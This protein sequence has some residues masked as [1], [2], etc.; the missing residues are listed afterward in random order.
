DDVVTAS[1]E[2]AG[3]RM[4]NRL[5]DNGEPNSM[6]TNKSGTT[7]KKYGP[8]GK[9]QKEYNKG[10]GKNAPKQEQTDHVHDYKPNPNNPTGKG[11]RMPGRTPK[12]NEKL[13]DEYKTR[14]NGT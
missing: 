5:P 1:A 9:V 8:D 13:K 3:K 4:K 12:P 2:G 11:D 6:R 10:H 7:T 14:K